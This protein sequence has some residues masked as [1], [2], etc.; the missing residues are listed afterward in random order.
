MFREARRVAPSIVYLPRIESLWNTTTDTLKATFMSLVN[1]LP[2]TMPL[3]LFATSDVPF[4]ML[5]TDLSSLFSNELEQV[6]VIAKVFPFQAG[7]NV[8][9]LR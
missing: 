2:P 9:C 1:D 6:S 8:K 4:T 7:E 3:L 5:P